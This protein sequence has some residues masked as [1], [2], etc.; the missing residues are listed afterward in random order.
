MSGARRTEQYCLATDESGPSAPHRLNVLEGEQTS[1]PCPIDTAT[2]EPITAVWFHVATH[3][4]QEYGGSPH[5]TGGHLQAK[6]VYAIEAPDW[7]SSTAAAAGTTSL[8]DGT[9]WKQTSWS[10]RAFFSLLSDPPALRLNRLERTDSGSYVCNVTYRDNV[11]SVTAVSTESRVDLFVAAQA[12]PLTIKD[13]NGAT[14]KDT[15]GPYAEG[16]TVRLTCEIEKLAPTAVTIWSWPAQQTDAPP[17]SAELSNTAIR[18]SPP[19]RNAST[20]TTSGPGRPLS[21]REAKGTGSEA[22]TTTSFGSLS[23][24]SSAKPRSFECEAS[25]SRP[26]ANVMWFLDGNAVDPAFSRSVSVGN[27]TTSM[28]LLPASEQWGRL[29]ECRA[30]NG[31]L[32][33]GRGMLSRFLKVDT[34]HNTEASIRLGV[35]LNSSHI[36]EGADVYMECSVLA[37]SKVTEVVWR[38]EGNQIKGITGGGGPSDALA[39]SRY[40]VIRGVTA[41]QS[42]RYTCTAT[43]AD[44]ESAESIPFELRVRHAPRCGVRRHKILA[45]RPNEPLN[46]TC[47]VSADP[48]EGLHYFWIAE[49]DSGKRRPVARAESTEDEQSGDGLPELRSS[50]SLEVLVD[51]H[52]L[53]ATLLCW[54]RNAVGT[55]REPCRHRFQLRRDRAS[56]LDCA[57]GN[58]TDTSFSVTC[59][60]RRHGRARSDSDREGGTTRRRLRIE[61]MDA[62]AGNRSVRGFWLT[63]ET[64]REPVFLT[65]LKPATEYLVV[66]RLET[67]VNAFATYVRTMAPAQTLREREDFT[68]TGNSITAPPMDMKILVIVCIAAAATLVLVATTGAALWFKYHKRRSRLLNA[69]AARKHAEHKAY[70]ASDVS[71]S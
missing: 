4:Y 68:P 6:R 20:A 59:A 55:Q 15:A 8:V 32:P 37:A 56:S 39:T 41:D 64:G 70:L 19:S 43:T 36:V 5:Y 29:L 26:A 1:L 25:G 33:E 40:L 3:A 53:H 57:V 16:D 13:A 52:L 58:Y 61:L 66:A 24:F 30:I 35:G 23:G 2:R 7:T 50:S 63:T 46:V 34:T 45:A 71:C 60:W 48:D 69:A 28:L 11:T 17:G 42:G 54:A 47:D 38:H 65:G 49:D 12:C 14:V 9:H 67:E 31:N 10:G 62:T 51:A 18:H 22:V 44:G 27:V 21:D